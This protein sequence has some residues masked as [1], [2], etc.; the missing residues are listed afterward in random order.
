MQPVRKVVSNPVSLNNGTARKVFT[1]IILPI[2]VFNLPVPDASTR[3]GNL[4]NDRY[5]KNLSW[6]LPVFNLLTDTDVDFSFNASQASL[7]DDAGNP[8]YMADVKFTI[9]KEVPPDATQ[10]TSSNSSV[11]VKEIPL[12]SLQVT[13]F[14]AYSDT[15]GN[16]VHPTY[17]GNI[18]AITNGN[19][20]VSF[21]NIKGNHVYIL[22]QNLK[23]TGSVQIAL[24]ATYMA[25][26]QSGT[27]MF[28]L[29][30]RIAAQNLTVNNDASENEILR[31]N[32]NTKFIPLTNFNKQPATNTN[33]GFNETQ[34][35]YQTI[36]LDK[37]YNGNKY[38]L[39]YKLSS[40]AGTRPIVDVNDLKNLNNNPTEF[41]ELKIIDL[42]K[43]P[44][45]QTLYIGVLSRTIIVLPR[46]YGIVRNAITCSAS[47]LALVDT[48]PSGAA[49]CRFQFQFE[50][51]PDVDP[52]EFIM[53]L[54]EI[55]QNKDLQNYK[56]KYADDLSDKNASVINSA[57][58]TDAN[59]VTAATPHNFILTTT[60][61]DKPDFFAV[62]GAN[63]FIQQLC[64]VPPGCV[65]G[66]INLQL[67][68]NY[69][70][71]VNGT[72]ALSLPNA[73]SD[74]GIALSVDADA[75]AVI[76]A[77]STSFDFFLSSYVLYTDIGIQDPIT[78]N[79]A[80][81]SNASINISLPQ[82]FQNLSIALDYKEQ[83]G[84]L[85]DRTNIAHYMEIKTQDVQNVA[86]YIG[87]N[88]AQV[89]YA[90]HDIKQIDMQIS[91]DTLSTVSV[92]QFSLV[93]VH[94]DD[95]VKIMLPLQFLVSSLPATINFSVQFND[96]NKA[97]LSFTKQNDF[98]TA[99][100]FFLQDAD[101]KA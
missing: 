66:S 19:Y 65:I 71:P 25:W 93:N 99:P 78:I 45:I 8:F 28:F 85:V 54:R 59:F 26:R 37:K 15:Q 14:L 44:S 12:E 43:Y 90:V 29:Q 100:L 89:N 35:F 55:Q 41:S 68:D 27:Q 24:S 7:P 94:T 47:C 39:S 49:S 62:A 83:S 36:N 67:D 3:K 17:T 21:S 96:T 57:Y 61:A 33:N 84:G 74:D 1:P 75:Q 38:Q 79:T 46:I 9:H 5:N 73:I 23:L 56:L 95:G 31:R 76:L 81:A 13:L 4:F 92:P 34:T 77:N 86:H 87:V 101:I 63:L 88:S 80:I 32:I 6:Y 11:K 48:T 10:L 52:V 97:P 69:P 70:N 40:N 20:E 30:K 91:L 82:S 51:A 53:L 2:R 16:E 60:I 64:H 98:I 42:S 72:I 58:A 22:Y 18:Q 50:L